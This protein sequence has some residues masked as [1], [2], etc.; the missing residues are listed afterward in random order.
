LVVWNIFFHILGIIIPTDQ[1]FSEGLKP[2]TSFQM[3]HLPFGFAED[4]SSHLGRPDPPA[5]P[6]PGAVRAQRLLQ[7]DPWDPRDG[8]QRV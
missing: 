8:E 4:V 6:Q 7:R 5:A 1:Y 3:F 2:P